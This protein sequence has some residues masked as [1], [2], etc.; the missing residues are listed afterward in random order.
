MFSFCGR[1]QQSSGRK[2]IARWREPVRETAKSAVF[3][4]LE[5]NVGAASLSR[6]QLGEGDSAEVQLDTSWKTSDML[7]APAILTRMAF[8]RKK[9]RTNTSQVYA[10]FMELVENICLHLT[11]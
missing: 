10:A 5:R 3:D 9:G 7:D 2:S 6:W 4:Q 8:E 11:E 1:S